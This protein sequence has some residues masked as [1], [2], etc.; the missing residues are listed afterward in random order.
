MPLVFPVM[1][2][3]SMMLLLAAPMRPIPKSSGG[4]K[5]PLPLVLFSRTRLLCPTIHMPPHACPGDVE[6]LRS[7]V[8]PCTNVSNEVARTKIP[9]PQLVET[10]RPSTRALLE[11]P[12][13]TP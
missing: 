3:S 1:K 8:L 9:D 10:V 2:F 6:P 4:S 13:C 12:T 7:D 5:Y 11:P